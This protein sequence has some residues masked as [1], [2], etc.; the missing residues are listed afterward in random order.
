MVKRQSCAP[1]S[2][3]KALMRAFLRSVSAA[4]SEADQHLAMNDHHAAGLVMALAADRHIPGDFAAAR[5]ER[6]QMSIRGSYKYLVLVKRE[7]A[8]AAVE[9]G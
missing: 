6:D 7:A 4:A 5:V 2:A 8:I 9:I 1:V 3:S